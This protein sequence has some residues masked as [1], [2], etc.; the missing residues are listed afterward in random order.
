ME[1][2]KMSKGSI[3]SVARALS[4]LNLLIERNDIGITE[5]A[6]ELGVPKGTVHGLVKTLEEFGYLEQNID[7]K[8]YRYGSELLKIGFTSIRRIELRKIAMERAQKLCNELSE[9]V[10]V[11]LLL[12]GMVVI[13]AR[14][15]P[16]HPSFML[17]PEVG[18]SIPPHCTAMG[19]VLLSEMPEDKLSEILNKNALEKYTPHTVVELNKIRENL[20]KIKDNGFC[21]SHQEALIGLSCTAAPIRDHSG[22]I[23][24]SISISTSTEQ[25]LCQEGK[26]EKFVE[27]IINSAAYIS[28]QMG[29]QAKN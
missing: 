2:L 7:N 3:Q 6:L 9:T 1:K 11:G 26:L 17:M 4:I 24:A 22:K 29:Y 20:K 28:Q 23:A 21:V 14:C 10:H 13:I 5:L 8:K 15:T 12:G 19:K 18:L 16:S 27:K 25:L